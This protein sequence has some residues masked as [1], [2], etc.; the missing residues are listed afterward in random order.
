MIKFKDLDLNKMPIKKILI[1]GQ[2]AV[3]IFMLRTCQLQDLT[4]NKNGVAIKM[5]ENKMNE[6]TTKVNKYGHQLAEQDQMIA[7]RDK[8]LEE[9]LLKNSELSKLNEQI[10]YQS[11]TKIKNIKAQYTNNN[12]EVVERIQ[13]VHDTIIKNGDTTLISGIPIGTKFAAQDTGNWYSLAG[14]LAADGV[15]FD[16]INFR[17]DVEVNI[18]MKKQDGYKGWLFGRKDP[19]VEIVNLN[20]YSKTVNMRNIKLE[21][22]KRWWESGWVKFGA[23]FLLGGAFILNF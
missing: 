7:N 19:K 15:K 21:D 5:Y 3:I 11:E 6:F 10:K 2:F 16:S 1:I 9:Q 14:E 8:D 22:P 23:G 17:S 20:P 12:G 18:G 4:I 13:L